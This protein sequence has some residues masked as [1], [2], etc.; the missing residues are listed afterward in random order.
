MPFR[1]CGAELA[2]KW[3]RSDIVLLTQC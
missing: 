2:R 1:W 3:V